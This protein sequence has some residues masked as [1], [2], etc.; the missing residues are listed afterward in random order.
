M[1]ANFMCGEPYTIL[2]CA[3]RVRHPISMIIIIIITKFVEHTNSSKLETEVLVW[4]GGE[5]D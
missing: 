3:F 1:R 2:E 5:H 4:Q